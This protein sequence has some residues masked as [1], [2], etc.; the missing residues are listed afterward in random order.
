[1]SIC[2]KCGKKYGQ[3]KVLYSMFHFGICNICKEFKAIVNEKDY[4][5]SYKKKKPALKEQVFLKTQ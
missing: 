3:Y 2:H 4:G 5:I 1:M